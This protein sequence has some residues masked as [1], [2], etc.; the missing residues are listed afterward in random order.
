MN[1]MATEEKNTVFVERYDL[2]LSERVDDRFGR[3]VTSHQRNIK[4]NR[5]LLIEYL[6]I[7]NKY[8]HG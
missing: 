6:N 4:M 1:K 7:K 2:T 5:E 3:I 8:Y